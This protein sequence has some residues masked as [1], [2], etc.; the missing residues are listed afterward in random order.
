MILFTGKATEPETKLSTR[1]PL[2]LTNITTMRASINNL[3]NRA[4]H[5]VYE[6]DKIEDVSYACLQMLCA[7]CRAA[8][9][10]DKKFSVVLLNVEP[11]EGV[12][13]NRI[14][15]CCFTRGRCSLVFGLHHAENSCDKA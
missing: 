9:L 6:V 11:F 3:L 10:M 5:L 4:D 8:F 1:G 13:F 15:Q 2:N 14:K 12:F 7:T